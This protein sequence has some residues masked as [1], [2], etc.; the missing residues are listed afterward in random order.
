MV[1]FRCLHCSQKISVNP[2]GCGVV[3]ACPTCSQALICPPCSDAEFA[4]AP[5]L[6]TPVVETRSSM[7]PHLAR[8][9]MDKLVQ[10]LLFQRRELMDTHAAAAEQIAVMEQ[11]LA[12]LQ[13]KWQR[14]LSFYEERVAALEVDLKTKAAENCQL[15]EEIRQL[16]RQVKPRPLGAPPRTA[17]LHAGLMLRT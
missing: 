1:K 5:V 3:I 16:R 13:T 10:G 6:L 15:Q 11:R 2:E 9:M 7:L 12:L 4:D 8:L 14:R 17:A